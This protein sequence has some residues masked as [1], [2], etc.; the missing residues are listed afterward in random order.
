MSGGAFSREGSGG[1]KEDG[2]LT[3]SVIIICIVA[4]SAGLIFGYDVGISGGVTTMEPFLKKF[5]PSVLKKMGDAKQN[6][7]CIFNS[8]I[9]T[10]FTSSLYIAGLISSL[11]A[12][13][14]TTATGRKGI[15]I[16]GGLVFL[17]GTALNAAAINVEMLIL[18]RLLLGFGIGFTNQAAP[19][20]LSEM[21]PPKWRGALSSGF[22]LFLGGGVVFATFINV[23]AAG[24]GENGWR[25]ALGCAAFPAIIMT[26]GAFFIPDT[27]SSL[28]QRGLVHEAR[29][30]LNQVRGVDSDTEA[31]LNDLISYN[32]A[33]K[34]ATQQPYKT[35]FQ[36]R[37]RPHLVLT[38]IIPSFQQLTGINIVAFYA[39]VL[40]RSIGFGAGG[41]LIGALILGLVN[42]GSTVVSAIVVD[43][44]GRRVL[45]LEGGIQMF[46]C[47]LALAWILAAELGTA[48]TAT[49]SKSSAILVLIL[50][51][52]IS[53]AFGWSWG[54]LTWIVPSEILPMEVR[55]AGQGICIASNFIFTFILAQIFLAILCQMKYGVFLFYAAWVLLMTIFVALFIPETKGLRLQSM[56]SIWQ[57]HWFWYRYVEDPSINNLSY[58]SI[59]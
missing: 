39:P 27:P 40:F 50:M 2:A 28:I 59:N 30:S 44:F 42:L 56:D 21:A 35:I 19:V 16:I 12:G 7:Y 8:Q 23:K 45:F 32:E 37:Y 55:P 3:A 33:S 43:R 15:L 26:V 10:L 20:Y 14:V 1:R 47:Q 49:F 52:S 24:M 34:A 25:V 11:I 48:G 38:A 6:Q 9:L 17:A 46:L 41:A 58:A 13:R 5:F 51:C 31:E 4:A 53:A 57:N 54:P 22:Q 18:G 29:A 36:R